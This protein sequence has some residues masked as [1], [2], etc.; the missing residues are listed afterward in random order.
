[1]QYFSS[2]NTSPVFTIILYEIYRDFKEFMVLAM[3]EYSK[4][5]DSKT[6]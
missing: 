2:G 4:E 3:L 1:M 6:A 5:K